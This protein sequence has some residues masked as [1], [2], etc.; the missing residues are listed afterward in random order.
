MHKELWKSYLIK[1]NGGK[2]WAQSCK[3]KT[4]VVMDPSWTLLLQSTSHISDVCMR[5]IWGLFVEEKLRKGLSKYILVGT[6]SIA[7]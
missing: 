2:D 5:K 4:L 1:N 6:G 3:G 7:H